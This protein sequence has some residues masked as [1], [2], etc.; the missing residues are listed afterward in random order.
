MSSD[1]GDG[2]KVQIMTAGKTVTYNVEVAA[3]PREINQGLMFR[4]ALAPDAGMLF[5]FDRDE[6]RYFWM[7]NTL[8]PLDMIYISGD[9][10]VVGVRENA[11][12]RSRE[13]ITPPGPCTYVLEVSG[14]ESG[15]QGICAGDIVT[16]S[17]T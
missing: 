1:N 3:T 6:N 9:S 5:V 16:I 2:A 17:L 8:I 13:P 11:V 7:E 14:G 10:R 4:T 12:P 15:R